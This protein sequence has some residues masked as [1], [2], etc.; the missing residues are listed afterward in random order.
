MS[1]LTYITYTYSQ[2]AHFFLKMCGFEV[3]FIRLEHENAEWECRVFP[4]LPLHAA[5]TIKPLLYQTPLLSRPVVQGKFG[6]LRIILLKHPID[7]IDP[8]RLRAWEG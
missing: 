7:R 2:S 4:T 6:S 3:E 5:Y 1:N 8:R